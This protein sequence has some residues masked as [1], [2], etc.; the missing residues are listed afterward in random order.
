MSL[1][2]AIKSGKEHRK[3]YHGSKRFDSTCCNHG[4]CGYCEDNR[5]KKL[6]EKAKELD[7]EANFI[8][9]FIE[10]K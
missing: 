7:K 6:R 9:N 4:S 3:E 8:V 5:T 10:K 1:S 2:K